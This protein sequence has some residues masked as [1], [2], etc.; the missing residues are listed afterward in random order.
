MRPAAEIPDAEEAA[1]AEPQAEIRLKGVPAYACSHNKIISRISPG[2][3]LPCRIN[4]ILH[5][6][7]LPRDAKRAGREG[8]QGPA[9]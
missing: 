2:R 8:G 7:G 9:A 3:H 1:P 6:S 5:E 4:R